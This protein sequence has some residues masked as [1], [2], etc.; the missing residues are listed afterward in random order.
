MSTWAI[1]L[2]G[3]RG[4]RLHRLV[5]KVYLTLGD[6]EMIEFPFDTFARSPLVS[7]TVVVVRPQDTVH[8]QGF[9][10]GRDDQHQVM[11][12]AGGDTRHQSERRGIEALAGPIEAGEVDLLAVHDGARPFVTID[13]IARLVEEAR[14]RGGAVPGL[15]V[16]GPLFQR[17]GSEV[18]PL[19][20]SGLRRVQ[21][22]QVFRALDLLIAYRRA[23]DE[24]FEGVDTAETVE[25]YS[26]L[27]VGLV[28]GDPG[29]IKVTFVEDLIEAEDHARR[30]VA[31][32]WVEG[33]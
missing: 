29:N 31:G 14:R 28:E 7:G 17:R 27:Q 15:T 18:V 9:L 3:G 24:G 26:D 33:G 13:L 2:A 19:D 20:S 32:R 12:V 16:P 5:N 25:R 1:L 11:V 10:A 30:F 6:R 4:E 22:P 8:V 23:E 21:T